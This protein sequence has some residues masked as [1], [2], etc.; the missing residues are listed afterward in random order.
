M[1][2]LSVTMFLKTL[3][4]EYVLVKNQVISKQGSACCIVLLWFCE[5]HIFKPE[6]IRDAKVT[7]YMYL[8]IQMMLL[9]LVMK[10]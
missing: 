9:T 4:K 7:K 3:I 1:Y 6:E 10:T 2:T 8:D 5:Y